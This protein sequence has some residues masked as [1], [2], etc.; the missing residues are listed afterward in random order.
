MVIVV[1][2]HLDYVSQIIK[3][4]VRYRITLFAILLKVPESLSR[5]RGTECLPFNINS[6]NDLRNGHY[7]RS[8]MAYGREN[9]ALGKSLP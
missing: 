6:H 7:G 8:N 2:V 1:K 3:T 5:S 4:G 9:L